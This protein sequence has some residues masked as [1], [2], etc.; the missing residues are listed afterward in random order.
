MESLYYCRHGITDDLENGIRNRPTAELTLMGRLQA[1]QAADQLGSRG[2]RPD[3]IVCSGLLRARQ[4]AGIIAETIGYDPDAVVSNELLNERHGGIAIGMKNR[5]IKQLYPGGFD[6]I[7]GAEKTVDLQDRAAVLAEALSSYDEDT[8]LAV[9]H[10]VV[11][12]AVYRHFAGIPYTDEY[13]R[14]S[15]KTYDLQNGQIMRLEPGPAELLPM[16]EPEA[17][18]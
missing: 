18:I 3:L 12:R 11:G 5:D 17:E 10:G 9:G 13:D 16:E 4:S 1:E 15:R 7:P 2:I 8:V 6:D 14:T